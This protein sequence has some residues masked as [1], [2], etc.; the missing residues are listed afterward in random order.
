MRKIEMNKRTVVLI[1]SGVACVCFVAPVFVRTFTAGFYSLTFLIVGILMLLRG[2]EQIQQAKTQGE[3]IPWWRQPSIIGGLAMECDAVTFF[4]D[5]FIFDGQAFKVL[6]NAF[7]VFL[8]LT[9]GLFIYAIILWFQ[10]RSTNKRL[11]Q[12]LE[13]E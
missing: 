3:H 11:D 10:Q 1:L 9:A 12:P 8:L 2:A 6:G 5:L 13:D 4:I 7:I